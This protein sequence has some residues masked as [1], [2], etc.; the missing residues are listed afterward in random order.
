MDT[1]NKSRIPRFL[2]MGVGKMI[3]LF[4]NQTNQQPKVNQQ[5]G[6]CH[7]NTDLKIQFYKNTK[8]ILLISVALLCTHAKGS[9]GINFFENQSL[10]VNKDSVK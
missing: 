4:L 5:E 3:L 6:L 9:F 8:I 7:S 10:C 2:F 1:T